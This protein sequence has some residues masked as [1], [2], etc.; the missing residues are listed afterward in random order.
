MGNL[1]IKVNYAVVA[2]LMKKVHCDLVFLQAALDEAA[3]S[4]TTEPGVCERNDC[5]NRLK[6]KGEK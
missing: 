1:W 6:D 4:S 2:E 5:P 3:S